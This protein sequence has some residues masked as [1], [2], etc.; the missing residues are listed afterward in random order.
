[1]SPR[2]TTT[3][4][5]A[6]RAKRPAKRAA[7]SP[8]SDSPP[9]P[10]ATGGLLTSGAEAFHDHLT[11]VRAE[12]DSRLEARWEQKLRDLAPHGPD[13]AAM[14]GAARD[15]TLRGGKR[16]RAALLA[17]AYIGVAPR[18]RLEPALEAGVAF[19]LLQSYLLMQDDWM[20]GDAVRRG[21]PSAHAALERAFGSAHV[22]A[23]AAILA[24]DLTW[25]MAFATLTSLDAPKA[26]ALEVIRLFCRVHEDVVIGQQ[27]D[28]MGRAEDVEAMHALKTGSYTVRGPLLLGAALAGAP[29]P[30][31]KALER[32]AAPLG[33][34]FQLRDDLLGTFGPTED[35]GKPP[36]TDLRAGKRT[37]ILAEA[38]ARLDAT[39]RSAIDKVFGQ[40]GATDAEVSAAADA[41]EACGARAAVTARLGVLCDKA[42][43]LS[44]R[45]PLAPKAQAILRG[46]AAALRLEPSRA[47]GRRRGLS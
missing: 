17:A 45:L 3:V 25:G 31:H 44:A 33:V 18:A 38:E 20:D 10:T 40:A 47:P 28:I 15:L 46:A 4:T 2:K 37:A 11:R 19:E 41:L 14:A 35:A 27:I 6:A 29:E 22:G 24:S 13:V 1:M 21:G 23:S 7:V 26:R 32:F 42:E 36:G 43:A 39:G 34:A 9:S 16:F 12:I 30:T 8:A 5:K